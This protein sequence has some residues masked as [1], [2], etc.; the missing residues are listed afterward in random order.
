[1]TEDDILE[2]GLRN[3]EQT[4]NLGVDLAALGRD[5]VPLWS[6]R[7]VQRELLS[8]SPSP[9]SRTLWLPASP[10]SFARIP[11]SVFIL[12]A[13]VFFLEVTWRFLVTTI[14]SLLELL[15]RSLT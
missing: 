4:R 8:S 6:A 15:K 7:E 12:S 3:S 10:S 14:L 5:G 11:S 1:M 13:P 2:D 9:S